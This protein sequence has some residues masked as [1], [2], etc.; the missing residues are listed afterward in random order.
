MN[1]LHHYKYRDHT[2][3]F[4]KYSL[5]QYAL[6]MAKTETQA[7]DFKSSV[8]RARPLTPIFVAV[9]LV[10]FLYHF[11]LLLVVSTVVSPSDLKLG[12][13]YIYLLYQ[14]NYFS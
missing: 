1:K 6:Y 4:D 10:P 9:S 14:Y 2:N 3:V 11:L 7:E 5:K 13:V 8:D 12:L